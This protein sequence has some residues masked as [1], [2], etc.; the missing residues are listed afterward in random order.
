MKFVEQCID[1]NACAVTKTKVTQE[2]HA[3]IQLKCWSWSVHGRRA[4]ARGVT[5]AGKIGAVVAPDV[6]GSAHD[7]GGEAGAAEVPAP[8]CSSQ[9]EGAGTKP[10]ARQVPRS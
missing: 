1:R 3:A 6:P 7:P 9:P 5:G 8:A 2:V 4:P 10:G